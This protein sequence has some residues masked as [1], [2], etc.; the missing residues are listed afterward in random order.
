MI[1]NKNF[2]QFFYM[3]SL[4]GV[5]ASCTSAVPLDTR[6]NDEKINDPFYDQSKRET[7]FGEGGLNFFSDKKTNTTAAG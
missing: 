2:R 5:L 1:S 7:I 3:V 4:I 6:S